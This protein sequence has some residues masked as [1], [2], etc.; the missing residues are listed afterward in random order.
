MNINYDEIITKANERKVLLQNIAATLRDAE[1]M[2]NKVSDVVAWL[3]Y[4]RDMYKRLDAEG[5]ALLPKRERLAM[6][7]LH[8]TIDSASF[9]LSNNQSET[10]LG[11]LCPEDGE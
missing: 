4:L 3:S 6:D 10:G 5:R 8:I 2:Y 11:Y 7:F 1:E 9:V